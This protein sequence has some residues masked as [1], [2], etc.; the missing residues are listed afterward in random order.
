MFRKDLTY[1]F[2]T[3]LVLAV[4]PGAAMANDDD[5][6]FFA[7]RNNLLYR[8]NLVDANID[9]FVLADS[10]ASM[11]ADATGTIWLVSQLDADDDGKYELY[12]LL[13]PCGTPS[14]N[15]IG[16]FLD[17]NTVSLSWIGETLYGIQPISHG[18]PQR[19]ITIDTVNLTQ[20]VI[21][22]TGHFG[23]TAESTGYDPV[24]N[25]LFSVNKGVSTLGTLDFAPPPA[26]DP[27]VTPVGPLGWTGL[28]M[29]G[30][31]FDG[32]YYHAQ[33]G[34]PLVV[35]AVV[36]QNYF[37]G[38]VDTA[39]GVFTALRMIEMNVQIGTV[40]LVATSRDLLCP[41]T[42]ACC[43][44]DA[45]QEMTEAD[46]LEM[47]GDYQG[48]DALC[49]ADQDLD[50]VTDCFDQCPDTLS[51]STVDAFGC[52]CEQTDDQLPVIENCGTP[53]EIS[54]GISCTVAVPDLTAA[55]D[56]CADFNVEVTQDPP[57]GTLVGAG[58]TVVTVTAI[59]FAGN[60]ASCEVT[61][62]VIVDPCLC[63]DDVTPPLPQCPDPVTIPAGLGCLAIIPN[64]AAEATAQDD[65]TAST[66]LVF[67]QSPEAGATVSPGETVVTITVEDAAGN[68]ASCDVV[69][70]V[71]P[72][73]CDGAPQPVP[74]CDPE[75]DK[76]LNI[77]FSLL[78]HAPVCGIGCPPMIVVSVVMYMVTRRR[79]SQRKACRR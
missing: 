78:F 34:P 56:N 1:L 5:L 48:D 22:P 20:T 26:T 39:T 21:G 42:G 66:E 79:R 33:I 25:T 69:V 54:A 10:F 32:V 50:G 49:D 72:A 70:T 31:F 68:S 73:G 43:L 59:D 18:G 36:G 41:P 24:T 75:T 57:A 17:R 58:M 37:L 19:L 2:C 76:S 77:L 62:T 64:L 13:D 7:T 52:A 12:T 28:R 29:G 27:T 11:A 4:T 47:N 67:S 3:L 65:C 14:L 23:T 46:C 16:D 8:F 40:G 51:T 38:K 60:Q 71:D 44:Q 74:P 6:I 63:E 61:V 45:C 53:L 30:E 55:S 35:G 9:Q 15:L